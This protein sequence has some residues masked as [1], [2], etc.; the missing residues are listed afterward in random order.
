MKPQEEAGQ[1]PTQ[2]SLSIPR[3]ENQNTLSPP[4]QIPNGYEFNLGGTKLRITT[5]V[6]PTSQMLYLSIDLNSLAAPAR[7]EPRRS[8]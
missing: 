1:T 5:E 6:T 7:A 2:F 8:R 3:M 4:R